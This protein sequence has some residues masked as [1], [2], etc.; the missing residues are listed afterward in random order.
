MDN[1]FEGYTIIELSSVLAGPYAGMM[2]SE[3]GATVQARGVPPLEL[4]L[5]SVTINI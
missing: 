4:F 1:I 3:L 2:F 5:F